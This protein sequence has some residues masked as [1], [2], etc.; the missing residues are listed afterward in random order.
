VQNVK[1]LGG[2]L[3]FIA[4]FIFLDH[5]NGRTEMLYQYRECIYVKRLKHR[6]MRSRDRKESGKLFG[7]HV[8]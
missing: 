4:Y 6:P 5:P 1:N 8:T 2:A 7:H 3:V